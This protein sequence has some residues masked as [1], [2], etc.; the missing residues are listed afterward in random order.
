MDNGRPVWGRRFTVQ[1]CVE[2]VDLKGK[3]RV[4]ERRKDARAA[5][6]EADR[7][8]DRIN[9]SERD[10]EKDRQRNTQR[11]REEERK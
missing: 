8:T 1:L 4:G 5:N 2:V 6:G 10:G 7:R 11:E 3:E 9:E